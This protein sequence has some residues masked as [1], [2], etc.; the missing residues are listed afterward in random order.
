MQLHCKETW[1]TKGDVPRCVAVPGT[2]ALNIQLRYKITI[3]LT[4][5]YIFLGDAIELC[6]D[7]VVL[8]YDFEGF[9]EVS[10]VVGDLLH[11][12]AEQYNGCVEQVSCDE[13]YVEININSNDTGNDMYAFV[14]SIAENIR[15]DIVRNTAC[16]ASIGIGPNKVRWPKLSFHFSEYFHSTPES[17]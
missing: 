3:C 7:L 2:F 9:E 10:G 4:R 6:P 12:Y 13:S 1:H 14:N 15:T 16:T 11:V 8:P 17:S 5:P